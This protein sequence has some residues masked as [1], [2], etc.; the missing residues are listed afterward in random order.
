VELED[1]I[2]IEI[3]GQLHPRGLDGAIA[4]V[5]ERQHGVI[6][7]RQLASLGAG[8]GAIDHRVWFGRLR[9]INRGVYGVGHRALSREGRWMAAVLAAGPDAVLSHRSAAALWGLRPTA[10]AR[11]EVTTGRVLARTSGHSLHR[12]VLGADEITTTD[13]IPTTTVPRTLLDL[14]AVLRP[15]ALERAIEQAEVLRL[16][17]ALPLDELFARHPG[18]RGTK[19]L[20]RIL[21]ITDLGATASPSMPPDEPSNRTAPAT[22]AF[23][24]TDGA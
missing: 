12:A 5:A 23:K 7:R 15:G 10:R 18:A 21:A 22:V 14:A 8:R 9:P 19:A 11:V 13:G 17:D 4:R 24:R 2:D 16:A 20:R 6:A 3:H 1:A